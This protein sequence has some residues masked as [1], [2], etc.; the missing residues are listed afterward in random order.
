MDEFKIEI[1]TEECKNEQLC[2]FE[3][4]PNE[5]LS[6]FDRL[7]DKLKITGIKESS[8][9]FKYMANQLKQQTN[10]QVDT[11]SDFNNLINYLL[12]KNFDENEDVYIV[13]S[14]PDEVD[15]IKLNELIKH[16]EYIWYGDSDDAIILF[17]K[18][19]NLAILITH[20]GQ[21]FWD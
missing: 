18:Q 12:K 4:L 8:D 10:K 6:F 14:F 16:W 2:F 21:I 17:L 13:W 11:K 5:C 3:L 9:L 1:F 7:F 20:Y 15:S 19:S